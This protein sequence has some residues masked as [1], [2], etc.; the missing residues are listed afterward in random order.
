MFRSIYF[1]VLFFLVVFV[2]SCTEDN[3]VIYSD[4]GHDV[5][6]LDDIVNIED[7]GDGGFDIEEDTGM[8][9]KR[10]FKYRAFSGVSMGASGAGMIGLKHAE[11]FDIIGVIGGYIDWVY[12]LNYMEKYHM[13][14][15][16]PMDQILENIADIND[17]LKNPKN[18][19]W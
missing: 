10:L 4:G 11:L 8:A 3:Q 16:C 9:Q 7:T 18:I 15:F 1:F 12:L 6:K 14:G 17:P 19:L 13:G 2:F 5:S